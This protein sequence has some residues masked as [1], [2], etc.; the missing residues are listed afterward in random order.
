MKD[1]ETEKRFKNHICFINIY[2][3]FFSLSSRYLDPLTA[4][5][6]LRCVQ[7]GSALLLVH[8]IRDAAESPRTDLQSS[9]AS[10]LQPLYESVVR[11]L[12]S[13]PLTFAYNAAQTRVVGALLLEEQYR[14]PDALF[15]TVREIL[16]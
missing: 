13:N 4:Q 3:Y 9:Q 11:T 5:L 16:I 6:P 8:A 2:L 7:T 12:M 15:H 10:S 1:T 14:L